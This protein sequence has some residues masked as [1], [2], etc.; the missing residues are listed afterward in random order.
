MGLFRTKSSLGKL[1]TSLSNTALSIKD[2]VH[3]Y[4]S[5]R[6]YNLKLDS[7]HDVFQYAI[8]CSTVIKEIAK[9]FVVRGRKYLQGQADKIS[10]TIT[11]SKY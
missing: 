11:C 6:A 1:S 5:S 4:S 7:K 8:G 9:L 10:R 2:K 3:T